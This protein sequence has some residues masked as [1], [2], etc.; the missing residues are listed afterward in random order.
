[1]CMLTAARRSQ[2]RLY[3]R[4]WKLV[5]KGKQRQQA[6]IAVTRELLGFMWAIAHQVRLERATTH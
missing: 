5:G 2:H 3:N 4:F 6:I 1:M